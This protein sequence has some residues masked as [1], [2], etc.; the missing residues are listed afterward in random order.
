MTTTQTSKKPALSIHTRRVTKGGETAIG[1]Q[2]GVGFAHGSGGGFSILLDAMPIPAAGRIELVA[3]P[4]T[5]KDE[6]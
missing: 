4:V 1:S 2:I 5:E 3:F 6:S